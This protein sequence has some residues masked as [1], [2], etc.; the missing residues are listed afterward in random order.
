M[1]IGLTLP[2]LGSIARR[3]NIIRLA[4]DAEAEGIDSLWVAERLLW[5]L[6]PQTPYQPTP[7]GSLPTFYQNVFDPLETLTFVAANTEKI[8]LGTS[9]IDMF[10]HNPVVLGRRFSTLDVFSQGRVIAGL[11]IGWSKD[12][13]Q[14]SN[15]PYERRGERADEYVQ[16]LKRIW[17]DD[18][19]EFKGKYYTIPASKIGPKPIHKPHIPIYLGGF[20][21]NTFKRIVNFNLDGWLASVGGP[22][23]YLDKSIKDLRDY[24]EK[25]KK[26]PNKF[27]IITLIFPQIMDS[28]KSNDKRFPMSGSIDQIGSD[29]KKIKGMGVKHV[30]FA[31]VGIEDLHQEIDLAKQ[32]ST[33]LK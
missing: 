4:V 15:V 6:N 9:V 18:V 22:L 14:V 1:K 29:L 26:D 10:F 8:A 21:S 33:F 30:V 31:F 16:L 19:V 3:E 27:E 32:L 5:P 20:S 12:E 17:T 25:A 13:Y 23:E 24:A 11:G 2:H 28:N 7:D